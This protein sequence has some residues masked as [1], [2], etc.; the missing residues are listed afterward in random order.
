M[1][2]E[3]ATPQ[4]IAGN[5]HLQLGSLGNAN[6]LTPPPLDRVDKNLEG[7]LLDENVMILLIC[8]WLFLFS[9]RFS[10][11][12]RFPV[13][14]TLAAQDNCCKGIMLLLANAGSLL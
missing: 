4:S 13:A 8:F 9:N 3:V 10:N 1:N 11:Y 5:A 12:I 7:V 2:P 6:E 14:S